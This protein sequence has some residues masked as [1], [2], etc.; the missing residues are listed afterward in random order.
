[1]EA[2]RFGAQ[3]LSL[4]VSLYAA[5]SVLT[6]SGSQRTFSPLPSLDRALGCHMSRVDALRQLAAQLSVLAELENTIAVGFSSV[7]GP[8]SPGCGAASPVSSSPLASA[9]PAASAASA[10]APSPCHEV[11]ASLL[12]SA[13]LRASSPRTRTRSRSPARNAL[14]GRHVAVPVLLLVC[15]ALL[16]SR[17]RDWSRAWPPSDAHQSRLHNCV[18]HVSLVPFMLLRQSLSPPLSLLGPPFP[19]LLPPRPLVSRS[20]RPTLTTNGTR[21][22]THTVSLALRLP[23]PS[24]LPL[25]E[26]VGVLAIS[27]ADDSARLPSAPCGGTSSPL[28]LPVCPPHGRCVHAGGFLLVL[29]TLS[30]VLSSYR[31]SRSL[32][33]LWASLALR[34]GFGVVPGAAP[35]SVSLRSLW[36][37]PRVARLLW[38][39][40]PGLVWWPFHLAKRSHGCWACRSGPCPLAHRC[41]DCWWCHDEAHR[42]QHHRSWG[43]EFRRPCQAAVPVGVLSCRRALLPV[44][45]LCAWPVFS[46]F[47]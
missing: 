14:H 45:A 22:L 8:A 21:S 32:L 47:A 23:L 5:F 31:P 38:R 4:S 11:A 12:R 30:W 18:S 36:S 28:P 7:I 24:R 40:L 27:V 44:F 3:G 33:W 41:G 35:C 39:A 16:P 34:A 1:M 6:V 19:P 25:L 15:V 37:S 20:L 2:C 43:V 42:A 29:C 13:S 10:S 46:T 26:L 17:S 9:V